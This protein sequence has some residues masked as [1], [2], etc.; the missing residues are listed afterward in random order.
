MY[1]L[2]RVSFPLTHSPRLPQS[3]SLSLSHTHRVCLI[4]SV[5]FCSLTQLQLEKEQHQLQVSIKKYYILVIYIMQQFR[6]ALAIDKY[7]RF[8][9]ITTTTIYRYVLFFLSLYSSPLY[10]PLFSLSH[11]SL[12][13]SLPC[14]L[15]SSTYSFTPLPNLSVYCSFLYFTLLSLS[16]LR[17]AYVGSV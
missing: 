9:M 3:L 6:A 13:C 11:I 7:D 1:K 17:F 12:Y 15:L 5:L 14:L 2:E 8:L 10:S 4:V 16:V